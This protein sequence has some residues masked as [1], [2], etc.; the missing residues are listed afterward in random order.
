MSLAI[1]VGLAFLYAICNSVGIALG[2]GGFLWPFAAA[3][4]AP[5]AFTGLAIYLI[6]TK[7]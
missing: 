6:K 4:L 2:K 5:V 7:F 3:W 1:A